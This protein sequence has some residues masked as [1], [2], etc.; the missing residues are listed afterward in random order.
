MSTSEKRIIS[1][2]TA[3]ILAIFSLVL[4]LISFWGGFPL[5]HIPFNI[6]CAN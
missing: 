4:A 6:L 3:S 2:K 5:S 1:E